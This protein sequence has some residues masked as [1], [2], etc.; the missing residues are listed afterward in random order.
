MRIDR[1]EDWVLLQLT[2]AGD[3][4]ASKG[5]LYRKDDADRA[6][7]DP[8]RRVLI[9][10]LGGQGVKTVARIKREILSGF[11]NTDG[12]IAFAAID[13][14]PQDMRLYTDLDE[15]DQFVIPT[16]TARRQRSE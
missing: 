14:D 9:V 4:D 8:H 10:G 15:R 13:T 1:A 6:E 5:T 7:P 3:A 2:G 11:R 16:D 12:R